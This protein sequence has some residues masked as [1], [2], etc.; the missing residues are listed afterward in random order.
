MDKVSQRVRETKLRRSQ[1]ASECNS[2]PV[3]RLFGFPPSSPHLFLFYQDASPWTSSGPLMRV[4]GS[5]GNNGAILL[6]KRHGA[7]G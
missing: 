4:S 6:A 5:K 1:G 3:P 7:P 2:V